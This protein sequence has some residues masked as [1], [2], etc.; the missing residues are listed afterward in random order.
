MADFYK[1]I[2]EEP[3]EIPASFEMTY[4]QFMS[5]L[6]A[7]SITDT[8]YTAFKFGY[9]QGVRAERAGKAGN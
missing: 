3:A 8:I 7:P 2:M 1:K 5:L 6:R 9:L 4:Q